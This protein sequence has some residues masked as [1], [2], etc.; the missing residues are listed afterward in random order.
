MAE[1]A[2]LV[3]TGPPAPFG[4]V[5]PLSWARIRTVLRPV[6]RAIGEQNVHL[7]HRLT[8]VHLQPNSWSL[9]LAVPIWMGELLGE[10][11]RTRP[12]YSTAI[13]AQAFVSAYFKGAD[14]LLD[15]DRGPATPGVEVVPKLLPIL[16][17]AHLRILRVKPLT[18]AV[19]R[20]YRR[21]LAEQ[22]DASRWEL[23]YRRRPERALTPRVLQRLSAKAAVL[24]WP[25]LF[26]PFWLGRPLA[27]GRRLSALLGEAFLVMQLLDDL[28]DAAKDLLN[29]Q[30][31]ALWIA[32]GVRSGD[33]PLQRWTDSRPAMSQ[34]LALARQRASRLQ[35]SAPRGTYFRRFCDLLVGAVDVVEAEATRTISQQTLRAILDMLARFRSVRRQPQLHQQRLVSPVAAQPA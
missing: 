6:A 11:I 28:I 27:E 16:A 10:D 22:H 12:W 4:E 25:A 21:L 29:G 23:R 24:K 7:N 14:D 30:P 18:S 32:A 8:S 31:N 19:A 3:R 5:S 1:Y 15:Q 2:D 26:V 9:T 20:D 13:E 33:D 17:E 35:Q 34:V